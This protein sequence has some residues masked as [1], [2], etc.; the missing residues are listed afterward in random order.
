MIRPFTCLA[1]L[2]A[3][4][5]GLYLYTEKHRTTLLDG[6]IDRVIADTDAIRARTSMLQ[7]EWALLNQPD[8]LGALAGRFLP[9]LQPI[10]PGQFVQ[11]AAL[12]RHLPPLG[13]PPGPPPAPSPTATPPGAAGPGP[14]PVGGL[15]AAP[16]LLSSATEADPVA[17]LD[18]APATVTPRDATRAPGLHA[19]PATRLAALA[20]RATRHP[21]QLAS[22]APSRPLYTPMRVRP[23]VS[24]A[25]PAPML[26]SAW[27]R[28]SYGAPASGFAGSAL[29]MASGG[30]ASGGMSS[31]GM[32]P[33]MA[34]P[35]R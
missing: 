22:A 30:M 3:A 31:S 6:R 25:R 5:S 11:L 20:H 32:A 4:G 21:V 8:R 17:R 33:P 7:A 29:G 27:S 23:V 2:L 26:A 12:D 16:L 34:A 18:G 28:P 35:A 24:Y 10:A 15:P 14:A 13:P 19:H 1:V 9:Q